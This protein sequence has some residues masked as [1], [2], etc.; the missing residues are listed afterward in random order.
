MDARFNGFCVVFSGVL[1]E[2]TQIDPIR[3][4]LQE[5]IAGA[6]GGRVRL[7]FS[8]VKRANS[9]GILSWFRLVHGLAYAVAYVNVPV[10]LV[11][12]FNF[13]DGL[14]GDTFVESVLAPFY[15]PSDDTHAIVVL[16]VGRELPLLED[17]SELELRIPGANGKMLEPDFEADEYFQFLSANREKFERVLVG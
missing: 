4:S 6:R 3:A 12:Q 11:E 5:A 10:W 9:V 16:T 1:D 15:C 8:Q 17:Y 2:S 13:A 7:D 14:R